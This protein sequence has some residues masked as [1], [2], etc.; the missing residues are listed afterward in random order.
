MLDVDL[1]YVI[2]LSTYGT[3]F[4]VIISFEPGTLLA[5]FKKPSISLVYKYNVDQNFVAICFAAPVCPSM[6]C[7]L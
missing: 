7:L 2:F 4:V 5:L 3:C 6:W 1:D